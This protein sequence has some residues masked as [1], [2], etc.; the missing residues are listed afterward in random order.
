MD[1]MREEEQ[2]K[3]RSESSPEFWQAI[4]DMLGHVGSM[5]PDKVKMVHTLLLMA[6]D[7]NPQFHAE[8]GA[9]ASLLV[10]AN[11]GAL[12]VGNKGGI[13]TIWGRF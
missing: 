6:A 1:P 8:L 11:M 2:A 3:Y 7:L 10:V 13:E 9:A 12:V 5:D 4:E